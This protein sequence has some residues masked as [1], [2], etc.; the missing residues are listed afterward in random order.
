MEARLA[1]FRADM[2][3]EDDLTEH[4]AGLEAAVTAIVETALP[5]IVE[6]VAERLADDPWTPAMA[7]APA[8]VH[9]DYGPL[10]EAAFDAGEDHERE[11]E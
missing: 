5:I 11:R 9:T 1:L 7:R 6:D 4:R 10:V 2:V 3:T 8:V